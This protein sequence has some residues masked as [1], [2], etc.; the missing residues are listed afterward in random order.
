VEGCTFVGQQAPVA[1]VGVDGAVVRFNTIYRPRAWVFRI[2]QE[3]RG[4]DFVPC[5][6]GVFARNLIVYRRD[7]IRSAVNI[8]P[9]TA[10]ETFRIERNYWYAEDGPDRSQPR[11]PVAESDGR[12]GKDPLLGGPAGGDYS[13]CD[14]SPAREFGASALPKAPRVGPGEGR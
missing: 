6:N 14:G 8:G 7:E 13:P 2:L 12:G 11:L 3:T 10:P 1:F 4:E 9:G 5:R